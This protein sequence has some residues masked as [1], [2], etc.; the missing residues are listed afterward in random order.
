MWWEEFEKQLNSAFTTCDRKEHRQVYSNDQKLRTLLRKVSADFL[1][2]TRSA[3]QLEMTR[4]P[5]TLTYEHALA[6]FCNEVNHK[7]PP[8]MGGSNQLNRQSIAQT[9][10]TGHGRSGLGNWG[11]HGGRGGRGGSGNNNNS[12]DNSKCKRKSNDITY[13]T[14]TD[15]NQLEYHPSFH[16][17][18][19]VFAK[20]KD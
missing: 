20:M 15:G 18:S 3:L 11:N 19:N 9:N 4:E 1:T 17:P 2:A 7:F 5:V 12:H 13:I 14:L 16:F 10:S 8:G 6:K